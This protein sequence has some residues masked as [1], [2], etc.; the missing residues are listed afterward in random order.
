MTA[1]ITAFFH[2]EWQRHSWWQWLLFPVA[3]IFSALV[4]LR[5]WLYHV[6][7]F[8]SYHCPVPVIVI[9]NIYIGGTGKTPLIIA[10]AQYLISQGYTPGIISRGYGGHYQGEVSV[11]HTA[12][13]VGDEPALIRQR[14]HCPVVV[15]P[16]R[17]SAAQQLLQLYPECNVV[18]SDDGLQ[19]Y[20]LQRQLEIVVFDNQKGL[21]NGRCLPAGPLREGVA[22]LAYADA[23]VVNEVGDTENR[24]NLPSEIPCFTMHL[25]GPSLVSLLDSQLRK[26]V[27]EIQGKTVHAVAAIGHPDRFFSFL[28]SMGFH[29]I[30]YAFNDHHA[31]R[32][33]DFREFED[34]LIVMT[35]KDAVKC[36]AFAKQNWWYLPVD[37]QLPEAFYNHII[38]QLK[39]IEHTHYGR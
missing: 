22:R 17:A 5:R 7:I 10:L 32:P 23:I 37:A 19:H 27:E 4:W 12:S 15:N 16:Q 24:I 38:N 33:E 11:T 25:N 3:V 28:R 29:V 9:G 21:G 35:E 30:P 18:L 2:R 6:G 14:T 34:G 31:F 13:L 1:W 26:S 36:R 20:A 39:Q 8:S